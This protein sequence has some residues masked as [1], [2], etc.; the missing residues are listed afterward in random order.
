MSILPVSP[1]YSC[2]NGQSNCDIYCTVG[3]YTSYNNWFMLI[4]SMFYTVY[5]RIFVKFTIHDNNIVKQL[6]ILCILSL[7]FVVVSIQN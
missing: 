3:P 7:I 4:F 1:K 2:D 6:F 5:N